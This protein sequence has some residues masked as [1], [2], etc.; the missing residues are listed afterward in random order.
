MKNNGQNNGQ[1]TE[2]YEVLD[3]HWIM[4][5][6]PT[7]GLEKYGLKTQINHSGNG[8]SPLL[9]LSGEKD[10]I[11][12]FVSYLNSDAVGNTIKSVRKYTV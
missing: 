7:A 12:D 8:S 11:D 4:V 10:K 9:E 1:V 2:K 5:N 3:A 6:V